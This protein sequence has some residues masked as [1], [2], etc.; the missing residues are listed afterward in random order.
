MHQ[1][2]AITAEKREKG[3]LT[4]SAAIISPARFVLSLAGMEL[5]MVP[6]RRLPLAPGPPAVSELRVADLGWAV[7]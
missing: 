6:R 5:L 7:A 4:F 3:V 2:T 1:R